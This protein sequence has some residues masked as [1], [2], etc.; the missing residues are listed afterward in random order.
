MATY[1][2]TDITE[3]VISEVRDQGKEALAAV[4]EVKG[5]LTDAI[6]DSLKHRPYT[7]LAF[8]VGVGFL[9]GALWAR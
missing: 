3:G 1:P 5:N 4:S 7:T 2:K 8:A 6:D 9:L